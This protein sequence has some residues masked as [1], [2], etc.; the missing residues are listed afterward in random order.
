MLGANGAS[1][2]TT[3]KIILG[4]IQKDSGETI[5]NEGKTIGYSPETPYFPPFMNER[6]VLKYYGELQGIKKNKLDD[7]CKKLLSLV[8]LDADKTKVKRYS[9]GGSHMFRQAGSVIQ[10]YSLYKILHSWNL[11]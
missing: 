5:I 8:G 2:S 11:F 7:E 3:I 6:E 1:K 9:R 4:L 10:E